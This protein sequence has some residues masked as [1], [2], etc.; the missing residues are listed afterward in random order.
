M[1]TLMAL[2]GEVAADE[3]DAAIC[4]R[5]V[6]SDLHSAQQHTGYCPQFD[7]LPGQ[8]TGDAYCP[9]PSHLPGMHGCGLLQEVSHAVRQVLLMHF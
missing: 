3:G 4:G 8:M 7:G 2:A 1:A 9:A 6:R 5:S